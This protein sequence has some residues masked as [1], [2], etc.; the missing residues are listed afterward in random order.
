MF[1]SEMIALVAQAF[2][3]SIFMTVASSIMAYVI[4]LP[5][6]FIL[7]A[8][9]EGGIAPMP[10]VN[11]ILGA[12]V[13]FFRSIPF[14]ILLVAI[15]PFTQA[16]VGTVIGA[17]AATVVLVV[18]AAPFVARMVET[19]L[20][21]VDRGVIEAAESMGATPFEIM[22]KVLLPE[23]MPSLLLGSSIVTTTILA[24]SAMAG[25]CGGGGLGA[26]AINY[27][28]YRGD[29]V[30]MWVMVV[31]IVLIVAVLQSAGIYIKKKKDKRL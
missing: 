28:Y 18:A 30:I 3:E 20:K 8:S 16:I 9:E 15:M 10:M 4:G 6:G 27:G 13:N 29:R 21:E 19:S 5:M 2:G 11:K 25:F 7:V 23:A 26:I 12:V 24:Y 17:K 22:R 31:L 1:D 14:L